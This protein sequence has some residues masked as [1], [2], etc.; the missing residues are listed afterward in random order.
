MRDINSGTLAARL[1]ADPDARRLRTVGA[2]HALDL[3][4]LWSTTR[5]GDDG[6]EERTNGEWITVWGATATFVLEKLRKG[7]QVILLYHLEVDE[8]QTADGKR[9][10]RLRPKIDQL[11]IGRQAAANAIGRPAQG[12]ASNVQVSEEDLPF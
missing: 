11:Q 9:H 8:W 7:D 10:S 12:P 4:V 6:Y 5:R 1:A 2:T 3:R